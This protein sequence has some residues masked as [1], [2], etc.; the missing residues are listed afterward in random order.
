M[1]VQLKSVPD[2]PVLNFSGSY[3]Y[4]TQAANESSFLG[5]R[6]GGVG[7]LGL[8]A[9]GRGPQLDNIGGNWDGAVGVSPTDAPIDYKM[10]ASI[11]D[12]YEFDNGVK[13]GGFMSLFYE[14]QQLLRQR[15]QRLVLAEQRLR[16]AHPAGARLGSVAAGD[17]RRRSSTSGVALSSSS[18]WLASAGVE[19]ETNKFGLQYLYSHTAE[20]VAVL[21]EDT[22]GKLF[23][24]PDYDVNDP[25]DPATSRGRSAAPPPR[26]ISAIT[27]SSTPSGRP[28]AALRGEHQ[29]QSD[30]F[31]PAFEFD[32]PE[33]DWT[34]PRASRTSTSRTS[35]SSAPPG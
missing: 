12:S 10:G 6:G 31:T 32:Q 17:S 27:R 23:Y 13:V 24:F 29:I 9:G 4:N 22:R 7:G 3:G 20:D 14:R 2:E 25:A 33:V 15:P 19:F 26:P 28:H 18:G 11:G 5:Y 8:E 34:L 16:G 35:A 21:A 1:N 30:P